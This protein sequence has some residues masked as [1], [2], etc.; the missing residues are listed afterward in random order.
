MD[1]L[2]SYSYG[3]DQV[4]VNPVRYVNYDDS[5]FTLARNNLRDPTTKKLHAEARIQSDYDEY[6][7][8]TPFYSNAGMQKR[9]EKQKIKENIED[10]LRP[11]SR[12]MARPDQVKDRI[13]VEGNDIHQLKEEL[14]SKPACKKCRIRK[15]CE[16]CSEP[17]NSWAEAGSETNLLLLVLV[18]ILTAF[19]VVQYVNT[20]AIN[21]TLMGMINKQKNP[22]PWLSN[23]E[24]RLTRQNNSRNL[25]D[26]TEGSPYI[27]QDTADGSTN[28]M[29]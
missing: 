2:D 11:Y 7:R 5:E 13:A 29:I 6:Q 3:Y 23:K 22:A 15:R 27:K 10:I 25:L 21:S 18:V 19:C 28:S 12:S 24:A 26:D 16:T 4:N 20:Q 1:F 9:Y 14:S 8:N 17:K